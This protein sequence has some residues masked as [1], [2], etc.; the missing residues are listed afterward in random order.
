VI[1][2]NVTVLVFG[3]V[4]IVIVVV[5]TADVEIKWPDLLIKCLA[6]AV[7]L[8]DSS[9]LWKLEV[10]SVNCIVS[11]GSGAQMIIRLSTRIGIRVVRHDTMIL[12]VTMG[13]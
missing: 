13:S 12:N 4:D 8:E 2:E 7:F 10:S 3:E 9:H 6:S 11:F 5:E 1:F